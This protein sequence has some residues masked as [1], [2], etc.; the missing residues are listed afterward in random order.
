M[1]IARLCMKVGKRGSGASHAGYIA[2]EGKYA[3]YLEKGERLE[4]ISH[5]NMPDWAQ[6]HP[7]R[8]WEAA[9][10]LERKNGNV[11]REMEIALPRELTTQQRVALVQDWVTQE[12]GDRH[13]YQWAIHVPGAADG[14]EQPHVHLM[15][16]DRIRDDIPRDPDEYFR[17]FNRDKPELGG[18]QKAYSG[19]TMQDRKARL[20]QLRENWQTLC[21]RHLE[22]AQRP[23]RIDMRSYAAQGLD[24]TPE[25]K[26]Q[27][28]QWRDPAQRQPV[29][30]Y[31]DALRDEQRASLTAEVFVD[32]AERERAMPAD[33]RQ[34]IE[35]AGN[36]FE[37]HETAEAGMQRFMA[38]FEQYEQVRRAE[39]ERL[40]K[41]E[42]DRKR[43]AALKL[44]QDRQRAIRQLQA[45][46]LKRDGPSW[47]PSF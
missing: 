39:A 12:I 18:C 43:A 15:F 38:G 31:R 1:A 32:M 11:Y 9:D 47:G 2:R 41:Q 4:A 16:S 33:V 37:L 21:N 24:R 46:K 34:G 20:M 22:M 44:E 26:M 42:L 8:F 5:G 28:G 40:R 10:A 45:Q 36:R 13:A 29:L 3:Q 35:D 6:N 7:Q 17:R 14:K 23:E 27:P 19:L 30:A 25:R